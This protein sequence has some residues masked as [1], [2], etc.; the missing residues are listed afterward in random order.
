MN[1]LPA[2][3]AIF[4]L[5]TTAI[6]LPSITAPP[7]PDF[8]QQVDYLKWYQEQMHYAQSD[9]AADAYGVFLYGEGKDKPKIVLSPRS[10]SGKQL[11]TLLTN[12]EPWQPREKRFLAKWVADTEATYRK[13]FMKGA[14]ARF[15]ANRIDGAKSI[16]DLHAPNLANGRA[17]GQ[18]ML[19][20]AWGIIDNTIDTNN[21][22][23]ALY[24]NLMFANHMSCELLM[25]EHFFAIGHRT[26]IY[27]HLAQTL[28]S[29]VHTTG[30]WKKTL[31]LLSNYDNIPIT[32][33]YAGSLYFA[34]A[35]A[36][37]RLQSFCTT[38]V[39]GKPTLSPKINAAVVEQYFAAHTGA[40]LPPTPAGAAKLAKA[41]PIVMARAIHEYY[42]LM[43][44]LLA[45][46]YASDLQEKTKAIN[47]LTIRSHPG[48]DALITPIDMVVDS[49]FRAE[50]RRRTTHLFVMMAIKFKETGEWPTSFDDLKP[51]PIEHLRRDP[52]TGQDLLFHRLG[53]RALI[54]S[55]G[56]DG[57]DDGGNAYKDITCW[58]IVPPDPPI[59]KGP[60]S[61]DELT[62]EQQPDTKKPE[63]NAPS[64]K[65]PTEPNVEETAQ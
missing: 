40:G 36:Y 53:P 58:A 12:P 7:A 51:A 63:E 59:L 19:V 33:Y 43:R 35:L 9:N 38:I 39:D 62:P 50:A 28:N 41:D 10:E 11:H 44:N 13:P 27:D 15:F 54:Y 48:L 45:N 14:K 46:P 6:Q 56:P 2:I 64:K 26:S 60:Q 21:L 24:A 47:N 31:D 3:S 65:A 16:A 22:V 4:T 8:R 30:F 57:N 42:Q 5:V 61:K 25:D 29:R 1:L 17:V 32:H 23:A 18:M 49:A 37:D 55:V 52:F 34:E 20:W